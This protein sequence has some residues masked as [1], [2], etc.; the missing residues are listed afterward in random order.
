MYYLP[1]KLQVS[2]M[3]QLMKKSVV[4]MSFL[5]WIGGSLSGQH[6]IVVFQSDFGVKDGAVAAMKGV[7]VG[8]S[9][10]LKLYDLT[11]EIPPFNI[12]EAAYRLRQAAP[13]WPAGTVFVSVVDPGV[14]S[15]RASVVMKSKSGHF[16]VT[17]DNGT[18]TLVAEGLGVEEIRVIDEA[19]NRLKNSH[20]SYTFHGRDVYAYTAARLASGMIRFE[21]V[22]NARPQ[23]VVTIP[24]QKAAVRDQTIYGTVDILDIQYG[25]LWTNIDA[26]FI[27]QIGVRYG[28]KIMV[29]IYEKEQLKF[30]GE[31]PFGT[32]FSD[33]DGGMPIAYIN[34]LNNFSVALNMGN[35]ATT[36]GISSGPDWKIVIDKLK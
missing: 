9:A 22:G 32:T 30:K 36:H 23:N 14:G 6:G 2:Q 17:P 20:A 3:R 31:I 11:H 15:D 24:Y 29:R 12:W 33:T 13:Y 34:S 21:E 10:D 25:N 26:K 5:I 19:K 1:F 4:V 16:F 18:L 27:E 28:D 35:F 7:A 8:V